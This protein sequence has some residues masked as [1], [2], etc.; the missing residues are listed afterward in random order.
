MI[1]LFGKS[2]YPKYVKD[3]YESQINIQTAQLKTG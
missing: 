2:P 1:H 3:N